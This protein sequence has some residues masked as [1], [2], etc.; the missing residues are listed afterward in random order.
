MNIHL[1]V[2]EIFISI[3]IFSFQFC[4]GQVNIDFTTINEYAFNTKEVLNLIVTNGNTKSINVC[5]NGKIKDA[6]G[7]P[8]VEFKTH[9]AVLNSGANVFTPMNLSISEMLY[10]NNDIAEIESTSGTYPSGNYTICIWATCVTQ[11]CNGLGQNAISMEEPKCIPVYIENP[12][13]LIL[14]TPHNEAE[15]EETK[16]LY[17]WIPP[18]PVA[19][20]SNLNYTMVLVEMLEG[21]SKADALTQNRPLIEVESK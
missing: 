20:S 7:N 11:D 6:A 15:I 4:H 14:A 12:T 13:P 18:A 1:T 19:G 8:V 21:Q 10:A 16:P 2:K 3:L 17:T 9:E 5:F